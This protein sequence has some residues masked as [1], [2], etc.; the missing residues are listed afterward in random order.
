MVRYFVFFKLRL[1]FI[2]QFDK[3]TTIKKKKIQHFILKWIDP[4]TIEMN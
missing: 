3:R 2:Y 1:R 4:L